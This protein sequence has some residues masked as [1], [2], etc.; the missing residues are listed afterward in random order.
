MS[1]S[2]NRV[3]L[4]GA[5]GRQPEVRQLNNGASVVS[6]SLATSRVWRDKSSGE[7][8]EDTEWH[9]L[10]AYD[11][12]ATVVERYVKTGSRLYVEGRLQTRKY[13][14]SNGVERSTTEIIVGE[15]KLL[16]RREDGDAQGDAGGE[17]GN[18]AR[19]PART[20]GA[21]A[22]PARR[23][24]GGGG[25]NA[26]GN[27]GGRSSVPQHDPM[28]DDV[29]FV[30]AEMGTGDRRLRGAAQRSRRAR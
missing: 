6:L 30:R 8:R 29:P 28:E 13:T 18:E 11:N 16:D 14:D 27:A 22:Q 10:V 19:R 17:S 21:P 23:T 26:G 25:G 4:M 24:A 12:L 5:V 15:L 7:R 1:A 3:T 20:G 9:R 2:L